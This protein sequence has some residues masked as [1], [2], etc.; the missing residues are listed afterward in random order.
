M[1]W[2]TSEKETTN[3]K[4]KVWLLDG[5]IYHNNLEI[6]TKSIFNLVLNVKQTSLTTIINYHLCW[7]L[8]L[9]QNVVNIVYLVLVKKWLLLT[10]YISRFTTNVPHFTTNVSQFTFSVWW[11]VELMKQLHISRVIQ[12]G[13]FGLLTAK[14]M[15]FYKGNLLI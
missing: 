12:V 5:I 4:R 2:E 13:E 15:K 8:S 3:V 1:K 14:N 7:C 6:I 10:T 9:N 11:V